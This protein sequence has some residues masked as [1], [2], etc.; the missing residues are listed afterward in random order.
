M[1]YVMKS[2]RRHSTLTFLII[3]VL[4][5]LVWSAVAMSEVREFSIRVKVEMTGIDRSR[6]AVV[7]ADSM[8]T[9]QVESSGFR[10][11]VYSLKG[12]TLT[13]KLDIN[14]ESVRRYSRQGEQG[15]LLCRAVSVNDL[16][17][18]LANALLE[19]DMRQ[20]GSAKDSLR[21]VLS[22]RK[23]KVLRVDISDVN[24]SFAEGYGLYGE[25]TVSPK[26]VTLYGDEEVLSKIEK[27]SVKKMNING[28][29][30]SGRFGLTLDTSWSRHDVYAS[31]DKVTLT[32]PVEQYV[33]RVYSIPIV[34]TGQDSAVRLNLYPDKV[35]LRVWVPKRDIAKVTAE[36][37]SAVADYRDVA[38]HL[39]SL[40]VRLSRFPQRV[41]IHSL[42]PEEVK[43]VVI[44]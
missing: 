44:K 16:G 42:T 33:E 31:T 2:G 13:L 9:L 18:K 39:N 19:M 4:T 25:P 21:I 10:A 7:E 40:K 27:V 8:V 43:Y 30:R 38:S 36:Q 28:L 11:F 29:M 34:V 20:V 23:S 22:E 41:R 6:F 35:S 17:D 1:V 32:V 12:K 15:Y 14:E 26:E 3:L 24:I 37:F 5:A